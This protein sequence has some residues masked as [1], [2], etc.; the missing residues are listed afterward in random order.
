MKL[1]LAS[2][3]R[4][5]LAELQALLKEFIPDVELLSLDD[6]GFAGE[7]EENG[8]TFEENALIK[9]RVAAGYGYIG[10]GD[11]SGLSVDALGGEPGI[12]SARYAAICGFGSA[13]DDA[14][15]NRCLLEKLK[16][17]PDEKRTA[18]F[19]TAIACVFP[20][21]REFTVRGSVEGKILSEYR[22]NSGFGYDPLFYYEPMKKTFAEL[23]A[24]E[25][26][27]I[28]HRGRAIRLFAKELASILSN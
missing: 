7:I 11:D 5:K 23:T 22:G 18:S 8:K 26:N 1:V 16:D 17:C 12:F 21:G 20:D 19:V 9:A 4:K 3:N 27:A 24:E 2:K 6:V 14:D 25:K 15:N 28:S 10:V 13:H